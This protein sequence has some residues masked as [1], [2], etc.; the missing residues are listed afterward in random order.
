MAKR[1]NTVEEVISELGGYNAVR[2]LTNRHGTP[3]TVLMWKV[4]KS[5]PPNTYAVMK[6][7][8][9]ARN[10]DAPDSLWNMAEA[11]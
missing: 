1:L 3:S 4:R 2:E 10:A 6:A 5:F 8:L 11:S 9:H 7:A